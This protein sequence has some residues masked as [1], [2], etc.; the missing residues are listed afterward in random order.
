MFQSVM[1]MRL[2]LFVNTSASPLTNGTLAYLLLEKKKKSCVSVYVAMMHWQNINCYVRVAFR[3]HSEGHVSLLFYVI[4][5]NCLRLGLGQGHIP[6]LHIVWYC[7]DNKWICNNSIKQMFKNTVGL[8]PCM[9]MASV[10]Y[11]S[12]LS[13]HCCSWFKQQISPL[14]LAGCHS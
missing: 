11:C 9:D 7:S 13:P 12:Y 4:F 6:Y 10:L 1:T 5:F 3:G 8:K 2:A 14:L